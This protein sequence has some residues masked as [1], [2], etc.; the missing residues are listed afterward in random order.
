M[1]VYWSRTTYKGVV[2]Q[3]T[4]TQNITNFVSKLTWS[5]A[6]TQASRQVTISLLNNPYDKNLNVPKPRPGDIIKVYTDKGKNPRFVGRVPNRQLTSDVGTIDILAY[7]YMH[8]MLSSTMTKKF[9]NKTPEYITKAVLKDCGI[10]AGSIVKTGKK[11]SKF[12]PSEMSPYDIII[13]AYRKVKAK[14]GEEYFLRMNGTKL[15]VIEKGKVF[16]TILEEKVQIYKTNYEENSDDVVNKVVVWKNNKKV[17]TVKNDASIK[18][19]GVL[20]QSISVDK[21]KGTSEAKKTLKGASK[22]AYISTIG[23]WNCIAGMGVYVK[24]TASG[25]T[26]EYWVKNDTHTW[27]NGIHTMDLELEFKNVTESVSVSQLDNKKK[28]SSSGYG[29]NTSEK[30]I[31]KTVSSKDA[32][33]TAY[34]PGEANEWVDSHDRRLVA[35]K[36]TCAATRSIPFNTKITVK[37]TKTKY[38]GKTYKVT[39]RPAV[40]LDRIDGK[41]HIDILMNNA[42]EC[43]DFGVKRGKIA[44]RKKVKN[45]DYKSGSKAD[46]VIKEAKKW[47]GKLSYSQPRRYQIHAGGYADC[48]SFAQ[49]CFKK[50]G[51]D[52]GSTT[53]DQ[54]IFGKE[55][56]RNKRKKGDLVFFHTCA[57]DHRYGASHVGICLSKKQFIHCSSSRNGVT[58]TNF[59]AYSQPIVRVMRVL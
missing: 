16:S 4:T 46:K 17:N 39:D 41:I 50:I 44:I 11:I 14:T 28:S 45:P 8:N 2:K 12:Y 43:N 36:K 49:H 57:T 35:S 9:K 37:G 6:S 10:T 32:V 26:G 24:D 51:I 56:N 29:S 52:I 23:D 22:S 15:D 34:Y 47:I 42:A 58:I 21:G 31:Y 54:V 20:Q 7:D 13:A 25:L 59:S 33:F 53:N 1:R 40:R 5:G 30:Y 38:D 27:E 55:V 48:S 3:N 19:Y 18:R